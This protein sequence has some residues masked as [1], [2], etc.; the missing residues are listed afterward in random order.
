MGMSTRH[1]SINGSE[2]PSFLQVNKSVAAHWCYLCLFYKQVYHVI[3][4]S[5]DNP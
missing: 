4:C 1:E 2:T 5:K 3:S